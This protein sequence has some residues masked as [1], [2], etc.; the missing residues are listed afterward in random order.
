MELEILLQ[1]LHKVS[2]NSN[3]ILKSEQDQ[4]IHRTS[5]LKQTVKDGEIAKVAD[6]EQPVMIQHT[7]EFQANASILTWNLSA[8]H[9]TAVYTDERVT[10]TPTPIHQVS[11]DMPPQRP[12]RDSNGEDSIPDHQPGR[13]LQNQLPI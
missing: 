3:A 6:G 1:P 13:Q 2:P 7:R 8:G 5:Q 11:V 10:T 4:M 12:D 9:V